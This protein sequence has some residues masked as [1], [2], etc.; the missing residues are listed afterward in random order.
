MDPCSP[1]SF[2]SADTGHVCA[3][4]LTEEHKCAGGGVGLGP[5]LCSLR[6]WMFRTALG[7][8]LV[9]SVPFTR[10]AGGR[11][12]DF[13]DRRPRQLATG[14]E[15]RT[16]LGPTKRSPSSVP[17]TREVQTARALVF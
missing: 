10:A 1:Q 3:R 7:E 13:A 16:R 8:F 6:L 12:R 17:L 11:V 14:L 9:S 5:F 15:G 4:P 2:L